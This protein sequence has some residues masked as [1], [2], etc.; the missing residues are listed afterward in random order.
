M[1][2]A[3]TA[4]TLLLDPPDAA[5]R[6]RALLG[7]HPARELARLE[8]ATLVATRIVSEHEAGRVTA[9]FALAARALAPPAGQPLD[10]PADVA[11]AVPELFYAP[12][13]EVWVV[14]VDTQLRPL[15]RARV[16][17]GRVNAC[18]VAPGD[19]LGPVLRA[20]ASG[21]WLLHNHPS[22]DPTPSREDLVV[23]ERFVHAAA[24]VGLELHDHVVVAGRLWA[25]CLGRPGEPRRGRF[26]AALGI[27]PRPL[28]A[29]LNARRGSAPSR[30]ARSPRSSAPGRGS[31]RPSRTTG[32]RGSS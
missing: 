12:V 30:S 14:G 32:T 20:Q 2:D 4:L 24:L 27:D 25:T 16:A 6:A 7:R 28:A 10:S 5:A 3:L 11:A 29:T 31:G 22:G 26:D 15:V 21:L 23:T 8:L 19:V 9:A 18:D 17:R 13:E 1:H